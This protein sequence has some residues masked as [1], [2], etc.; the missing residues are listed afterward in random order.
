VKFLILLGLMLG[1]SMSPA[2]ADDCGRAGQRACTFTERI[3]SCDVNL[4]EGAG[5][6]I[7]P[8]CGAEGQ[9]PCS[10][11]QRMTI[12]LLLKIPVPQACDV[13]LKEYPGPSGPSCAHPNCGRAGQNA[14]PVWERVPS[15]DINLVE[16]SGQCVHPACGRAGE[17]MCGPLVRGPLR[18]CDV[19]LVVKLNS[20]CERPGLVAAA[21]AAQNTP[22]PPPPRNLPPPPPP[23][24]TASTPPPPAAPPPPPPPAPVASSPLTAIAPG[25][26]T[27]PPGATNSPP[28]T[29]ASPRGI[30]MNVDRMGSDFFGFDVAGND[31]AMCQATCVY[32]A[33]CVAWTFVKPGVQGP[34]PR[35]YLKNTVP[36]PTPNN[37]CAS[38]LPQRGPARK[39]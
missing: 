32:N 6:C 24:P 22:P 38:G 34:N 26:V 1:F 4:V 23:P 12:D 36:P 21:T 35:C 15:C 13:D 30:E 20:R 16:V 25:S 18:I 7:R 28:A 8:Q 27:L 3:P 31:P 2:Q 5:L 17:Q 37:C 19:N 11:I 33:Q 9:R 10:P 14:C 29:L 39:K